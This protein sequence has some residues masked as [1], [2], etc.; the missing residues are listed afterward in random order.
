MQWLT[1]IYQKSKYCKTACRPHLESICRGSIEEAS[2]KLYGALRWAE[3]CENICRIFLID[4]SDNPE[5]HA[6]AL[7]DR[8]VTICSIVDP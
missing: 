6:A 3:N 4:L 1:W 8:F 5:E 2:Q 7:R